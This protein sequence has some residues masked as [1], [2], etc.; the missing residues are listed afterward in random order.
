MN[1]S[2]AK[3]WILTFP[4]VASTTEAANSSSNKYDARLMCFHWAGGNGQIF[5]T[6]NKYLSS[7]IH[8]TA[9]NLPGRLSR[10]QEK[11]LTNIHEIVGMASFFHLF[12]FLLIS[13]IY[14]HQQSASIKA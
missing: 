12:F 11:I 9:M 10:S 1:L 6:W 5:R 2:E 4:P 7:R 8:I 13:L 14:F 3:K